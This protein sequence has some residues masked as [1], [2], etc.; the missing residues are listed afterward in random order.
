MKFIKVKLKFNY[1]CDLFK[2]TGSYINLNKA[3]ICCVSYI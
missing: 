2:E 1:H 3:N